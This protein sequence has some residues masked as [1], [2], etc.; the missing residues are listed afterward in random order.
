MMSA[1]THT[2]CR[3]NT[4]RSDNCVLP[5][6]RAPVNGTDA[7]LSMCCR[8]K[9]RLLSVPHQIYIVSSV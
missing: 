9:W 1:V 3:P 8:T 5:A 7:I 6:I 2:R 4:Y